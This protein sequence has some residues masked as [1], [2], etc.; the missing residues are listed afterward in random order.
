MQP[1]A[2][3]MVLVIMYFWPSILACVLSGSMDG[4]FFLGLVTASLVAVN[5][6]ERAD[7]LLLADHPR[8][9]GD[10]LIDGR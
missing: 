6:L 5:A 8:R 2:E 10:T 9:R 7:C 4:S 1:E 3:I